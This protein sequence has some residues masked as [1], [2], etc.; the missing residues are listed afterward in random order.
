MNTVIISIWTI[1]MALLALYAYYGGFTKVSFNTIKD[2]GGQVLVYKEMQ[3]D[4]AQSEKLIN[5]VYLTLL[6]DFNVETYKG[7]GI[8]YDNPKEVEKSKLR[9]E[10]GC[11]LEAKDIAKVKEIETRLKVKTL[12]SQSYTE[13]V[14]PTKGKT[15]ILIA[16]MRVYPALERYNKSQGNTNTGYCIEIYDEANKEIVYR[17]VI[18]DSI[19]V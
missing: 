14:F 8:F 12:P 7:F 6:N 16:V 3:G 17:Q 4:Y 11:I 18:N 13:T 5:E 2:Q 10:V 1:A 15:S 19:E 9:S